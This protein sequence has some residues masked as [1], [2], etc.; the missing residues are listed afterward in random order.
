MRKRKVKYRLE[1]N[2]YAKDYANKV[3]ETS[4]PI[5]NLKEGWREYRKA[6]KEFCIDDDKT[7]CR[8]WFW[9]YNYNESGKF[10]PITIARNYA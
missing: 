9:K 7:P 1:V 3:L 5:Y 10:E 4:A 2:Y 8:V 6:I